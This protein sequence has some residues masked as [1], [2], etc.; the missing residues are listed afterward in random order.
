MLDFSTVQTSGAIYSRV[1]KV[2]VPPGVPRAIGNALLTLPPLF[3]MINY[4]MGLQRP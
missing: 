4:D 2:L 1:R 3:G